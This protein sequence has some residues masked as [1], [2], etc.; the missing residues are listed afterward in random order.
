MVVPPP[1]HYLAHHMS[2]RIEDY[3]T[4]ILHSFYYISSDQVQYD[5]SSHAIGVLCHTQST[6][7]GPIWYI[8]IY[9]ISCG[10]TKLYPHSISVHPSRN[11]KL[12]LCATL[13]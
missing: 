6:L 4:H 8:A 11:S 10:P 1:H 3:A 13:I 9:L 5:D 12:Y 7:Y 2:P